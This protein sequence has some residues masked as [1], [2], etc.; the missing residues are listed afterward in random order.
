[1]ARRIS[2]TTEE[3]YGN[4]FSE[5]V[6][7][8]FAV[9]LGTS[10]LY[11]SDSFF[12]PKYTSQNFWALLCVYVTSVLSLMGWKRSV[13]QFSYTD[14]KLGRLRSLVDSSIVLSYVALLFFAEGVNKYYLYYFWVFAVVFFLYILSGWLRCLEHH[15]KEASKTKLLIKH[16]ILMCSVAI[17]F[18]IWHEV[19]SPVPSYINWIFVFLPGLI[20]LSF[21][22]FREWKDL[23]WRIKRKK[24]IAVDLDGVLAEQVIPVLSRIKNELGIEMTKAE[25]T[26]WALPIANTNIKDEIEKALRDGDFISKMPVIKGG[27][28]AVQE[29]NLRYSVVIATARDPMTE[30]YTRDWLKK[31]GIEYKEL[32]NTYH[33]GKILNNVDILIDDY[34]GNV[35][36]FLN[37]GAKSKMAIL[38]S[39][40][41][42]QNT[43]QISN[44]ISSGRVLIARSWQEVLS[45]LP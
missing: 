5:I 38:F 43:I 2:E 27:V 32:I 15:D 21:R 18:T 16:L 17:A 1:M 31:N 29:L 44:L 12:P 36:V 3:L 25:M 9:V 34:I 19:Y 24:T 26:D 41:W 11:F 40:P 33:K 14:T 39:Q 20:M 30:N 10:L 23:P 37:N 28:E 6:Q 22:W 42:N 13:Q 45:Y 4:R 35:Q 8:I 7:I